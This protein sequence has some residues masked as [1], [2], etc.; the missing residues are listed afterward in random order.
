[1]GKINTKKGFHIG[2]LIKITGISV[3]FVL[4]AIL[5][6]SIISIQAIQ[7]SSLEAAVMMGT[8]KLKSDM[9][10]FEDIIR[11]EYGQLSL[12]DGD[13]VGLNGNS[14]KYQ[15]ETIDEVSSELSISATIFV[16]ENNDYRR[17]TT[18]II[19]ETGQRAVDTFLG[20]ASAAY[21]SIQAG[22]DY[23]GKAVILGNNY[24]TKYNPIFASNG[25]DVI[26]IL[27]IGISMAEIEEVIRQHTLGQIF[28]ISIIAAIIVVAAIGVN[29]LSVI[30][31]L[32]R[33]IRSTTAMLRELSEGEGDLTKHLTIT[34]NDEIGDLA[35]YFNLTLEHISGLI[36]KIKYKVNALTNT[37]HE[38]SANM[39]KT[40]K[41][42]ENISTNFDSMKLMMNKQEQGATEADSAVKHIKTNIDSLNTMI[43][44]QTESIEASSTAIEEM[45]VNINS[46]TKTLIENSKNVDE[47]IEASGNG[48]NGLQMVAE[49]I[50]EIARDSEGLLEINAVM[51][52]IAS[53][54]NL[55]SMNAAIEAAHAGEAG[56]GFA[57][58]ADE[59][60]KLAESSGAQS[61]TTAAMLKKI[62]SSIDSITV[63]SNDVLS[64]FS[65]IE[66]GVKTVSEHEQNIRSAMEEQETGG[67]QILESMGRLKEIS[68]SVK[69]GSEGTLEAGNHLIQQTNE[70]IKISNDAVNGINDLINGAMRDIKIAVNHV[71][72]MSVENNRNFDELR[73]ESEKFKVETGREKKK[74]VVVDGEGSSLALAK[75]TLENVYEVTAVNSGKEA[76]TLFFQGLV[77]NLVLLD[78]LMPAADGWDTYG[79]IKEISNIH[80]VP[81]AIFTSSDDPND[82]AHAQGLEAVDFIK[83][84]ID[85]TDLLSKIEKLI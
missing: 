80:K 37:S 23:I 28:R 67:K 8:D 22:K 14:L 18:S 17:I 52:N 40:S 13:M 44:D 84:P 76:L 82:R 27:F 38:L 50:Q 57:V 68:V 39:S 16:S 45:T 85:K 42:T 53:Q 72:E 36:R 59:I 43:E 15:Y 1:M 4:L 35:K 83:K 24:I 29:A 34:S 5:A 49:K 2:L 26:G 3:I 12:V 20:A 7:T 10:I 25:K 79:R 46:V 81:I 71:D 11:R 56:K 30:I 78:L 63:S 62:K 41:A 6:F 66:T 31:Q 48:K 47:L 9:L 51:N 74:I 70:F 32:L 60:R 21:P 77:P 33:P 73:T 19:N 58:V 61:K 65:D 64:S 55:L 54:T 75:A 69:K